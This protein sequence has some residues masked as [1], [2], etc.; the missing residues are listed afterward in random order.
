MPAGWTRDAQVAA[1][2]EDTGSLNT[3]KLSA[4]PPPKLFVQPVHP[5]FSRKA[6]V[7]ADCLQAAKGRRR[8]SAIEPT[9]E[10]AR[11]A[12]VVRIASALALPPLPAYE[13]EAAAPADTVSELKRW[14]AEAGGLSRGLNPFFWNMPYNPFGNKK[15][16]DAATAGSSGSAAAPASGATSSSSSTDSEQQQQ[17]HAEAG[18]D[19]GDRVL[20]RDITDAGSGS[21]SSS[22][23]DSIASTGGSELQTGWTT[24]HEDDDSWWTPEDRSLQACTTTVAQPAAYDILWNIDG[25]V[26]KKAT[27]PKQGAPFIE[28]TN[29]DTLAPVSSKGS[30]V[31][32][33]V[34]ENTG[35]CSWLQWL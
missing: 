16:S 11:F 5:L 24:W 33:E 19:T 3:I 1:G 17:Q 9:S 30:R 23:K 20:S 7:P 22:L 34:V 14:D 26:P 27:M 2:N 35:S 6:C 13:E 32:K 8:L 31:E 4:T 15:A 29:L 21:G 18:T 28:L 25:G 12:P 10:P